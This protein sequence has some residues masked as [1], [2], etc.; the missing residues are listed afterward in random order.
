[1]V[2]KKKTAPEGAPPL[3]HTMAQ[4]LDAQK[5]SR[6]LS[7]LPELK[8]HSDAPPIQGYLLI[9]PLGRGAY[10]QVWEGIQVRTRKFV[11]VKVFTKKSGVYWFYLQR[12]VDRLIRLDKHP[13]IVSLLDA[14]LAG[15]VPYYVMDLAQDGSLERF[16]EGDTP[17]DERREA[18]SVAGWMEEVAQAL[19]YVHAKQMVHC[20]LKPAN[21]LLDEEGHVRVADFG[22][23][24]ILSESGGTLGT[25]FFMAPEQAEALDPEKPPQPDSRWDIYALGSTIYSIL[26]HHVP[27][28][29]IGGQLEGAPTILERLRI[30]RDAIRTQPVPELFT[31]TKGRVDRDLSAIVAKCMAANPVERYGSAAEVLKDLKARREGRP[32]SPLSHDK[33][34]WLAKILLRYRVAVWVGAVSLAAL[35]AAL[36]SLS[37]RQRAQVQ[38]TAFNYVLRG[39][40]FLDKGDQASAVAY[41][42]ASNRLFPSA[43]ARGNAVFYMP[44][45]PKA[46]FAHDGP[47]AAV[48]YGPDGA[49]LLTA[50]GSTGAKLW[51]AQ[52]G[53]ALSRAFQAPGGAL[54]AAGLSPDG[55]KLV[56]GGAGGEA[57]IYDLATQRAV[58][59]PLEHRKEITS[60]AFSADG[61]KV[62]T[63]GADGKAKE[64]NAATGESLGV[65][66]EHD[67]P[68]LAAVFNPPG[69]R[70]LTVDKSGAVQLWNADNGDSIGKSLEVTMKGAPSWYKPTIAFN[71]N[72]KGFLAAGWDG[73]VGFYDNRGK[74]LG[75]VFLEGLGAKAVYS[76]DGSRVLASVSGS[77]GL[78][79]IINSR[80]HV[81][82]KF[83]L[84]TPGRIAVIAFSGDG[85]RVLTGG[86]DHVV[87]L[88][89][90]Q[91][92]QPLGLD[93]WLGD[94]VTDAALDPQGKTLAAGG[95]DGLACLWALSGGGR[96]EGVSLDWGAPGRAGLR[97]RQ[98]HALFSPDLEE[99]LTYGG[100]TACLWDAATGKAQGE[101][102]EAGAGILRAVFSPDGSQLLTFDS[103]GGALLWDCSTGK[104]RELPGGKPYGG[105]FSGD[106]KTILTGGE[107]KFLRLW[108]ASSGKEKIKPFS[109][110][111]SVSKVLLSP[112][113]ERA[114]ALGWDGGLKLFSLSSSG[115]KLLWKAEKGARH[116]LFSPDGRRLVYTLG[117]TVSSVDTQAGKP[118]QT[119]DSETPVSSVLLSPDNV[120]AATVG[121]DGTLRL[122]NLETGLSIGNPLQHAGPVREA[123]FSPRGE[124]LLAVYEDGG[125]E[126]WDTRTG[127][128][129][130][131]E[132]QW[133]IPI[134]S[135][136]F[137]PDDK[138]ARLIGKGGDLVQE[139]LDWMDP[140]RDAQGLVLA[141]EVAGRAVVD[142]QGSLQPVS[143]DQWVRLWAQYRKENQ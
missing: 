105:A 87:R 120:T 138:T 126:F 73:E 106:G 3:L 40:E 142:R 2:K 51:N 123:A 10:A 41:F 94:T 22:N 50:G 129:I 136:G 111:F 42:A 39:K 109:A 48:A 47:L 110:G 98:V 57:R 89:D 55:S 134:Q 115:A 71:P 100:K 95:K 128:A 59:R 78:A 31:L 135:A 46:F 16:V 122:F 7:E 4:T 38:D 66:L 44:P 69:D 91:S 83:I 119:L 32:V 63:A 67:Q 25:L 90:A 84:K 21:L 37:N 43:L 127:E 18:D 88:W 45:V 35:L 132:E 19:S 92:G 114:A 140:K 104:S 75:R 108:D 27:H 107:D 68:I 143:A 29:E 62:L 28:A 93:F 81:P 116:A 8:Q 82:L 96:G 77:S 14:D 137:S 53:Q 11:A 130:G 141:T 12:E 33:G 97:K 125:W 112:D 61:R 121:P 23:S 13:H 86:T 70:A 6:Q 101:V 9:K 133:G 72:G 76:P 52:T 117:Q 15:E 54:T 36:L 99:A 56:V 85:S 103:N 60:V 131:A 139:R 58:G 30:Y 49:V 124:V 80:T 17:P 1:M 24:R 65:V 74:R 5:A 79:R 20:D 64:W 34:Y 26:A 118:L 102:L 113:G